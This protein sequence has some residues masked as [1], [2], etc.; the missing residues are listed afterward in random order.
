MLRLGVEALGWCSGQTGSRQDS[1]SARNVTQIQ[2]DVYARAANGDTGSHMLMCI[3][4]L[5]EVAADIRYNHACR[6]L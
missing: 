4:L 5:G 6:G 3:F 1:G 2:L